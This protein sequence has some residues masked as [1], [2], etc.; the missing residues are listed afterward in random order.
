[1]LE[2]IGCNNMKLGGSQK[3]GAWERL[4]RLRLATAYVTYSRSNSMLSKN[5]VFLCT[6]RG[7]L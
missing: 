2:W 1:M 7:C 6:L 3:G 5:E 4:V